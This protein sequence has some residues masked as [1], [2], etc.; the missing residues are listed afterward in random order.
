MK[1]VNRNELDNS[2]L[3]KYLGIEIY[4]LGRNTYKRIGYSNYFAVIPKQIINSVW[5]KELDEIHTLEKLDWFVEKKLG[6]KP[7]KRIKHE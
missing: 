6:I 2:K 1:I 4:I 7:E 3:R 5:L